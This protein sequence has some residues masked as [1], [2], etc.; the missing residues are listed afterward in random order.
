VCECRA[1][2]EGCEEAHEADK[3]HFGHFFPHDLRIQLGSRKEGQQHGAGGGQKPK[4]FR[5]GGDKMRRVK[6]SEQ[7]ARKD[8]NANFNQGD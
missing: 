3:A 8:A 7:R 2:Q 6:G 1:S 5:I 4:P